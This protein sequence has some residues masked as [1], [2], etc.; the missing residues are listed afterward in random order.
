MIHLSNYVAKGN[1]Y[2]QVIFEVEE[3]VCLHSDFSFIFLLNF[4]TMREVV[5]WERIFAIDDS[6]FLV[7]R[8]LLTLNNTLIILY[9]ILWQQK[10]E[11][12]IKEDPDTGSI[13]F[14]LSL[15]KISNSNTI[16]HA[17]MICKLRTT[18]EI[19]V[20]YHW[21]NIVIYVCSRVGF[22]VL[23]LRDWK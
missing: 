13:W 14:Q 6:L 2:L 4:I 8:T 11:N 3:T 9:I 10:M 22:F 21:E 16:S 7:L 20:F 12:E 5:E 18:L 17:L 1:R 23:H 19:K 15:N